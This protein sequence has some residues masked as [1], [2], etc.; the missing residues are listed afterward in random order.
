MLVL[1][2]GCGEEVVIDGGRIRVIVNSIRDGRV[3]LGIVAPEGTAVDRRE[4]HEAIVRDGGQ[5]K[6]R[7]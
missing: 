2:R 5:R 1:T 3:R 6:C 4:V 7:R